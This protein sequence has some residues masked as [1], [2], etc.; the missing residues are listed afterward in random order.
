MKR[1]NADAIWQ[2]LAQLV[3]NPEL[4][5]NPE[6]LVQ[7][8][9][10][11]KMRYVNADVV[12]KKLTQ[13]IDDQELLEKLD[14][15]IE[16]NKLQMYHE[17]RMDEEGNERIAGYRFGEPYEAMALYMEGGFKTEQEALKRWYQKL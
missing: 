16:E 11:R 13:V 3:N 12:W 8:L 14:F 15:I 1:S 5:E 9:G 6:L 2:K 17:V 10:G 7:E 4:F